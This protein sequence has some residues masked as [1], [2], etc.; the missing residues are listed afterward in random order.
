MALALPRGLT[1][2]SARKS[3]FRQVPRSLRS[4]ASFGQRSQE[5]RIVKTKHTFGTVLVCSSLF[6]CGWVGGIFSGSA[7]K[8]A[9]AGPSAQPLPA[10]PQAREVGDAFV[11]VADK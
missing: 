7:T 3:E 1:F 6:A 10:V 5:V 4:S 9:S 8:Q 11:A 2:C